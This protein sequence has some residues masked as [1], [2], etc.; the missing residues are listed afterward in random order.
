MHIKNA[1]R[2]TVLYGNVPRL[3][4]TTSAGILEQLAQ[5]NNFRFAHFRFGSV[6]LVWFHFV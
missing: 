1:A 3:H 2:A 5:P 6:Q 4:G